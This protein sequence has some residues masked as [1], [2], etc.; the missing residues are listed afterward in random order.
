VAVVVLDSNNVVVAIKLDSIQGQLEW[1]EEAE[2]LGDK[3]APNLTKLERGDN[4][5][6][7]AASS[8]DR[9]WYEQVEAFSSWIVGRTL[10]DVQ[11]VNLPD[12]PD[13]TTTVT[14]SVDPFIS[15]IEKAVSNIR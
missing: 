12:E 9:E 6:M 10:G 15:V 7:R 4:Y 11:G 1:A 13:L 8:I 5:G 14:L 3:D 2:I